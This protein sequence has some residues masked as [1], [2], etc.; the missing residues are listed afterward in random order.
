MID[1]LEAWSDVLVAK[2]NIP[3]IAQV[4]SSQPFSE[5]PPPFLKLYCMSTQPLPK[6]QKFLYGDIAHLHIKDKEA[7]MVASDML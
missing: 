1:I 6:I 2:Q 4:V 3:I 7:P 5:L